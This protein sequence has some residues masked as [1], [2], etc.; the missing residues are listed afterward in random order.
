MLQVLHERGINRKGKRYEKSKMIWSEFDLDSIWEIF[1]VC[2]RE[3]ADVKFHTA[4]YWIHN[5]NSQLQ[6]H[7]LPT[8]NCKFVLY[9]WL[10]RAEKINEMNRMC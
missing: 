10:S 6:I 4:L 9:F 5:Q 3:K 7:I 1:C 8:A 2:G